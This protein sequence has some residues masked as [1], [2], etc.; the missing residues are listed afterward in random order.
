MARARG[1][2]PDMH[3]LVEWAARAFDLPRPPS[4]WSLYNILRNEAK[5]VKL[6]KD[7]Y[8]YKKS[9]DPVIDSLDRALIHEFDKMEMAMKTLTD[10]AL[11]YRSKLF[12]EEHYKSLPAVKRPGFS[13][14]WLH[15]FKKRHGIRYQRKQGEAASVDTATVADGRANMRCM[16]DLYALKWSTTWTRRLSSTM[17]IHH[18]HCR[19]VASRP[20]K[21]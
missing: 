17:R 12:V 4:E 1:S 6:P 11:L 16:T 7:T 5:L 18:E 19:G 3:A 20:W 15:R 2:R 8:N 14:G 9:V 13:K 10:H 21:K